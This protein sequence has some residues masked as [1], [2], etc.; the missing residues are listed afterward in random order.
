MTPYLCRLALLT[1]ALACACGGPAQAFEPA[2]PPLG[3]VQSVGSAVT[4]I[5]PQPGYAC[6]AHGY[7]HACTPDAHWRNLVHAW[8]ALPRILGGAAL[9]ALVIG[10]A[11]WRA[12][13][14]ARR[15]AVQL[16]AR[17]DE[18][19]RRARGLHDS[20]LQNI[21]GLVLRLHSALKL[22]PHESRARATIE[23][24]LDQADGVMEKS[25]AELL[26]LRTGPGRG[27]LDLDQAFAAFGQALQAQYGPRFGIVVRGTPR[28]LHPFAWNTLFLIGREALFN[29]YQHAAAGQIELELAYGC[30]SLILRVRDDGRGIGQRP[31]QDEKGARTWGLAGMDERVRAL[32]GV[33]ALWTRRRAGTELVVRVPARAVYAASGRPRLRQRLLPIFARLPP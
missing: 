28:P 17:L 20:L 14:A 4:Q 18:R 32:E 15:C 33:L 26:D 1:A 8:P 19:E 3:L 13:R 12:R 10:V 6:G 2:L 25:R 24:I 16:Q 7:S 30:R 23:S 9:L 5:A 31:A 21:Q 29:A 27:G 11:W 22:L